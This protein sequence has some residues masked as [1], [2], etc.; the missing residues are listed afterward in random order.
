MPEVLIMKKCRYVPAG[1]KEKIAVRPGQ[2]VTVD[3]K[4]AEKMVAGNVA[5]LVPEEKPAKKGKPGPKTAPA[6]K[7]KEVK[8]TR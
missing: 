1:Q 7:K 6:N 2:K 5:V 8:K 3:G 4:E